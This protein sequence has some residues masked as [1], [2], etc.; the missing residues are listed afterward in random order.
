MWQNRSKAKY[1]NRKVSYNGRVYDSVMEYEDALWLKDL[2]KKGEIIDLKE[3]VRHRI[4]VNGHEITSAI[5]D[6]QFVHKGKTVWYECKGFRTERYLIL[7]KL[8]PATLPEGDKYIVNAK[9]LMEYLRGRL[10]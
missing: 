1:G 4:Y 6:F 8:I 2:E 10:S 9:A 7:E 3:Q 5:V